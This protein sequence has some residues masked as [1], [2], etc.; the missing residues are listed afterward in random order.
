M[1]FLINTDYMFTLDD[2]NIEKFYFRFLLE[3]VIKENIKLF[4]QSFKANTILC[5]YEDIICFNSKK[6][7][8]VNVNP[9][10]YSVVRGTFDLIYCDIYL[11]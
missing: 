6:G 1:I 2:V 8:I 11:F 3:G 5:C 4:H 10:E 7:F 9:R